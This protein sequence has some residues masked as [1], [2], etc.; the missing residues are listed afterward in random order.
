MLKM[1][2]PIAAAAFA[3]SFLTSTCMPA[4]ED[5]LIVSIV[6]NCTAAVTRFETNTKIAMSGTVPGGGKLVVVFAPAES[7]RMSRADFDVID[8]FNLETAYAVP[9]TENM[10]PMVFMFTR[11]RKHQYVCR[12]SF[13]H[14]D[15]SALTSEEL[16]GITRTKTA[17][18]SRRK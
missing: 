3:M 10:I 6:P 15:K 17:A 16:D 1:L 5:P 14:E 13:V 8:L 9:K 11:D 7:G 18:D 12:L 4:Q 2:L